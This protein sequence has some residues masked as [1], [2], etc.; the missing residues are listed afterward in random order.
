[1][2]RG[3]NVEDICL[4]Y[5]VT[6]T[7]QVIARTAGKLG[8]HVCETEFEIPPSNNNM[9]I[10]LYIFIVGFQHRAS[11]PGRRKDTYRAFRLCGCVD[12]SH[13]VVIIIAYIL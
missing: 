13:N 3:L 1:V 6:E 10:Y 8:S 7:N 2:K 12:T 9:S 4:H 5:R 11:L